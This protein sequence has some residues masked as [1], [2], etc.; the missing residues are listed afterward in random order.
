MQTTVA[1]I[2]AAKIVDAGL[3]EHMQQVESINVLS[4]EKL[5]AIKLAESVETINKDT[6]VAK[7]SEETKVELV[8][9]NNAL[10]PK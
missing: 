6:V 7:K 1:E 3:A 5:E 4:A 8:I 10:R 2:E 9:A